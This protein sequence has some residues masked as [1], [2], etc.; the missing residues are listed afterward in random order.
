MQKL[1]TLR[2]PLLGFWTTAARKEEKKINTKNS[3]LPKFAPLVLRTSLRPIINPSAHPMG[4]LTSCDYT[5]KP[6]PTPPK[7]R[8]NFN[9]FFQQSF[10]FCSEKFRN[11][12]K[13]TRRENCENVLTFEFIF[14]GS[15][16][17]EEKS[18]C[19]TLLLVRA[20]C[21][22]CHGTKCPLFFL[23]FSLSFC[24]G[25]FSPRRGYCKSNGFKQES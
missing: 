15:S 16:E 1:G 8:R 21:V 9:S 13:R 18:K 11:V 20:A 17:E 24:F 22:R 7:S 10:L 4:D 25:Y 6:T 14:I 12:Q 3:G 19:L 23:S 2:Q 5:C